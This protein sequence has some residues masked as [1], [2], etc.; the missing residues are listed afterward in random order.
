MRWVKRAEEIWR[1]QLFRQQFCR[2][3]LLAFKTQGDG[4]IM[5]RSKVGCVVGVGLVAGLLGLAP[6]MAASPTPAT[7]ASEGSVAQAAPT[8]VNFQ[9]WCE[10]RETLAES[11]QQTID[12]LLGELGT[13]DCFEANRRASVMTLLNLAGRE[14]S[15][16]APLSTFPLLVELVLHNNQI[17]DISPLAAL[18]NLTR[19]YLSGN[20]IADVSPLA[21]LERLRFLVL[22]D[23]DL[24]SLAGLGTVDS[25][26]E[27]YLSENQI[28]DISELSTLPNLTRLDLSRNQIADVGPLR[29]LSGLRVLDL[30]SNQIADVSPL[31]ALANLQ[32][33]NLNRNRVSDAG[34]LRSLSSLQQLYLYNNPVRNFSCPTN[35][36]AL[37]FI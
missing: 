29:S 32:Q 13:E 27:L 30:N 3:E 26:Q 28:T 34:P 21:S 16:L 14:L 19:L 36:D 20:Q 4:E 9:G 22:M 24:T 12:V 7:A 10:A 33:L 2:Q 11:T 5:M 1:G 31:A 23:N 6:G 35:T 37:C 25:L 18:P 15:D 17:S 8:F